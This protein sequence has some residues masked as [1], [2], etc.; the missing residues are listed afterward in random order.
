MKTFALV[1][2]A[3]F[4][5]NLLADSSDGLLFKKSYKKS[6]KMAKKAAKKGYHGHHDRYHIPARHALHVSHASHHLPDFHHGGEVE[7]H[8]MDMAHATD[9]MNL[10]HHHEMN[11]ARPPMM[12]NPM[13]MAIM[14]SMP[15]KDNGK[16]ERVDIPVVMP[17]T[18]ISM[19]NPHIMGMRHVVMLNMMKNM[20]GAHGEGEM[21]HEP[22]SMASPMI[23]MNPLMATGSH[24]FTAAIRMPLTPPRAMDAF[25]NQFPNQ[26]GATSQNSR[27]TMGLQPMVAHQPVPFNVRPTLTDITQRLAMM[28]SNVVETKAKAEDGHVKTAR[29]EDKPEEPAETVVTPAEIQQKE[30]VR[31]V[32]KAND[33]QTIHN[34]LL[35]SHIV[36][37]V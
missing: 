18:A 31:E 10:I 26:H 15:T 29:P 9:F 4:V 16:V 35:R 24:R 1:A 12:F 30:V 17:L 34:V 11:H 8:E 25:T 7:I 14:S 5:L 27:M 28:G 22:I 36:T 33:E 2:I 21:A 23:S 32:Q 19:N 37:G 13:S 3:V 6:M 20:A